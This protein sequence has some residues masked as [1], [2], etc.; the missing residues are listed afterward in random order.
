MEEP[1]DADGTRRQL[2]RRYLHC[3]GPSTPAHF[4]AWC[5]ISTA[6]AARSLASPDTVEVDGHRFVLTDDIERLTSAPPA[7]GIRL[8]PPRDPYLLDRDRTA[9]VPDRE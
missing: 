1:N 4:A 5:G 2:V 3:Y 7:T 9:L 8:L 6:D